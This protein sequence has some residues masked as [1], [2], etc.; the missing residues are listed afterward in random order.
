M[1]FWCGSWP[2]RT[3]SNLSPLPVHYGR[4]HHSVILYRSSCLLLVLW[5]SYAFRTSSNFPP[6]P[7]H[8]G[9]LHHSVILYRSSN[10]LLVLW[11]SY[12]F[13]TS[14]NFPPLPVHYGRLHHSV[15]VH[16][17]SCPVLVLRSQLG[18]Q[19]RFYPAT[20]PVEDPTW[21]T[22]ISYKSISV[23]V[24]LPSVGA[25]KSAGPAEPVLSRHTA[26]GGSN[27]ADRHYTG[28][29]W[30]WLSYSHLFVDVVKDLG[31]IYRNFEVWSSV[32][33]G[34]SCFQCETNW[35]KK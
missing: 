6:L 24:F 12:A 18:Q 8:Y 2:Y 14:S 9:R 30:V 19:N 23:Q 11:S 4:H 35:Y 22:D 10:L 3:S 17:S 20:P 34:F 13:R 33:I 26:C 16:R 1:T 29:I 27:M 32:W 15:I 5:S 7:V 28:E 31:C 25:E 21:R